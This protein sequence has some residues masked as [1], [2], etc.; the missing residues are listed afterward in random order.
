MF[1][2]EDATP[3]EPEKTRVFTIEGTERDFERLSRILNTVVRC[4][5]R[6]SQTDQAF[7]WDFAHSFNA[8]IC[9]FD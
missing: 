7:L 4:R 5:T 9:W 3:E 2:V 8:A 1:K 6:P